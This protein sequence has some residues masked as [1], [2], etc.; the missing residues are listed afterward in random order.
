MNGILIKNL[1]RPAAT[2]TLATLSVAALAA[3]HEDAK[4]WQAE[5]G[6]SVGHHNNFFF[7]GD[8]ATSSPSSTLTRV[9]TSGEREVQA[10]SIDWTLFGGAAATFAS[11]VSDADTQEVELGVRGRWSRIRV[12]LEGMYQPNLLFSEEGVGTFYDHSGVTLGIRAELP[13]S[14]WLGAEYER[15]RWDFDSADAARDADGDALTATFRFP[16]GDRAAL[17]LIGIYAKKDARGPENSW[18]SSGYGAALELSPSDRWSVFARVRS[19]ERE[20]QDAVIG[21]TNF[22]R[23][24]TVVDALVNTRVRIGEHWGLGG[25]V[26][27]RDGES[28]RSDR[29][30]DALVFWVSAFRTF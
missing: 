5:I 15:S 25:Q 10:G 26:E 21:D 6:A 12:S 2:L 27:Y 17:R 22:G 24:D 7:R 8:T 1:L 20:Y 28:T 29:N 11:G 4:P 14:M 19:R 23:D 18:N 30:Y 9:Y 13:S 3:D 16:L